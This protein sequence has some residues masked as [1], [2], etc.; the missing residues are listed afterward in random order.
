MRHLLVLLAFGLLGAGLS[1]PALAGNAYVGVNLVLRAGPDIGYPDVMVVPA[2]SYVAVQ[3]C[4]DDYTWC[5]VAYGGQRGWL[6]ATYLQY[7]YGNNWVYVPAYGPRIGIPVVSFVLGVYWD[8][9]YRHRS[10]YRDRDR[11]RHQPPRHAP[12]R[13]RVDYRPRR[14]PPA[15]RASERMQRPAEHAPRPRTVMPRPAQRAQPVRGAQPARPAQPA[16]QG[17]PPQERSRGHEHDRGRDRS[18]DR[19]RDD[20]D[21]HG[22][23]GRMA[24]LPG[25]LRAL[26]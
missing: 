19:G 26:C 23:G 4:L 25:R 5:D 24:M 8:S 6:A 10:W 2:G 16:R 1:A 14:P 17:H 22:G 9:H 12:P 3:G 20:R 15:L 18:R 11:W 21:R 7:D 13:R